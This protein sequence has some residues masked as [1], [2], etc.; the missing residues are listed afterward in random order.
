M[1]IDAD[2]PACLAPDV[3]RHWRRSTVGRISDE[4]E[5]ALVLELAGDVRGKPLP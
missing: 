3:Y 1:K 5:T 4:I 2:T